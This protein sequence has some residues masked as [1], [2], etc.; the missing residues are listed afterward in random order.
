M[1][2]A[3]AYRDPHRSPARGVR[4]GP[5]ARSGRV[6][7]F[8]PRPLSP[9]R[10][11]RCVGGARSRGSS[12]AR[13][14]AARCGAG[15]PWWSPA[16]SLR[17]WSARS[18][19]ATRACAPTACPST[20]VVVR[21][22]GEPRLEFATRTGDIVRTDL[23]DSKSGGLAAGDAVDVRYDA[24]D[25]TRVVTERSARRARHH[26]VDHGGE[27]PHRGNGAHDRRRASAAASRRLSREPP[28]L[29]HL[30]RG[31]GHAAHVSVRMDR[32]EAWA[33]IAARAH[34]DRHQPPSRR[35]PDLD[36]DV[37]LR[38]RRRGALPHARAPRRRL[39]GS[40]TTRAS[41]S[42]SRG[43]SGGRSCGRCT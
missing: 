26:S 16:C 23:P 21:E 22:A 4:P 34:R 10:G 29:A 31:L 30:A 24:D 37:V 32:D 11:A 1:R 43:A 27:V 7:R 20:A 14:P 35:V 38:R 40:A 5:P 28:D 9:A 17:S 39:R 42:W 8:P 41:A 36:P 3:T 2:V 19:C 15:S 33:R 6:V 13:A 12:A 18:W 25:P